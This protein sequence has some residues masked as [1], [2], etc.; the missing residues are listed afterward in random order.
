MIVDAYFIDFATGTVI[1]ELE[2][3]EMCAYTPQ[4]LNLFNGFK[5]FTKNDLGFFGQLPIVL[6]SYS[7]SQLSLVRFIQHTQM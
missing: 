5:Q 6:L 4:Q 7:N 2:L 1:A 3:H